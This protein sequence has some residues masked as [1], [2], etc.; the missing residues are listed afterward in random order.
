MPINKIIL[1]PRTKPFII[2]G[3]A[4]SYDVTYKSELLKE[5]I[6]EREYNNIM[7]RL[8]DVLFISYPC[9]LCYSLAYLLCICTLGLSLIP[10]TIKVYKAKQI[11]IDEINFINSEYFLKKG[12]KLMFVE[13]FCYSFIEIQILNE[14]EKIEI[15]NSNIQQVSHVE[16]IM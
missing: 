14:N 3:L 10:S 16:N 2:T 6:S 4:N 13:G 8:M 5:Y 9:F 7:E 11:L 1:K 12:L 15:I